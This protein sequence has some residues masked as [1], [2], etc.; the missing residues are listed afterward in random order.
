MKHLLQ[1][2]AAVTL[3]VAYN[4]FKGSGLYLMP[5]SLAADDDEGEFEK[6]VMAGVTKLQK[7]SD[8]LCANFGNLQKETKTA[9]EELTKVKNNLNSI[10]EFSQKL[11]KVELAM[12]R[13]QRMA[14]GDPI[15]RISNDEE[16]RTRLNGLVRL[17]LG[18]RDPQ[19]AAMGAKMLE[20][21]KQRTLT[22]TSTPGSSFVTTELANEIYDVLS[23]YG[24]WKTLTVQRMG[25]GTLR[26]PVTTARP[27]AK[28]VRKLAGRKMVEDTNLA[29]DSA[30]LV[31]ELWGVMLGV[32]LELLQ[33]SEFDV[34]NYLLENF[35][36]AIAYRLDWIAFVADGTDDEYDAGMSGIFETATE[37]PAAAGNTTI[38]GMDYEDFLL[39]MVAVDPV[40]LTRPARWWMHPTQLARALSIKDGNGRS[41]FLTAL[42][43]PSYAGIGSILG[44]PV[45]PVNVAP[46]V[47][48]A[49]AKIA[50]FGDP[51]AHVMGIR[52]DFGFE[53][54]DD[55]AFD[56]VKR[57]YRGLARA[58]SK[59]RAPSALAVL[60]T[61]A[62]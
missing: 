4:I 6:G 37:V 14:Y 2:I 52:M 24:A 17:A 38:G 9:F 29:G 42:E 40:V 5:L 27:I 60:T 54:S 25:T 12:R 22:T 59:T 26:M 36:E 23:S 13:E 16:L 32:E 45:T 33:D 48:S 51:R 43:A 3:C 41:I 34:T 18:H 28:A 15:Q 35:G 7:T 19:L 46:T 44:Y 53:A 10:E 49:S 56:A 47:N 31:A 50:V 8:D 20:G 30:D 57:M 21:M 11:K 58:G 61:A 62:S 39:A 55:F 1:W